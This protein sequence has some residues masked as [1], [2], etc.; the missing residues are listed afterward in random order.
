MKWQHTSTGSLYKQIE[1]EKGNQHAGNYRSPQ[2]APASMDAL[3]T[4]GS[5]RAELERKER[6]ERKGGRTKEEGER[7]P[8]IR[9]RNQGQATSLSACRGVPDEELWRTT[10]A[11]ELKG[12]REIPHLAPGE[13]E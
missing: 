8:R 3:A 5:E 6:N 9:R 1:E 10:S 12:G 11:T 2:P 13:A 7:Q 4:G